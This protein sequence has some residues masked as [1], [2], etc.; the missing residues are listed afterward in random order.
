M[1]N[2]GL[3]LADEKIAYMEVSNLTDEQL[4]VMRSLTLRAED[5]FEQKAYRQENDEARSGFLRRAYDC[6]ELGY[7]VLEEQ[8]RRTRQQIFNKR[9]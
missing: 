3:L 5:G 4:T 7:R 1:N 8:N 6:A 2:V 9:G